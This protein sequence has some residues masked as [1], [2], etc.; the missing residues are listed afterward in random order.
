MIAE[1]LVVEFRVTGDDCPV[2]EASRETGTTVDARPPLR[3]DDGNALLHFSTPDDAVGDHLD[4]HEAIRYLHASRSDGR[5]NYRC[6]AKR[7]CVVHELIDEGFL[8][9]SLQFRAGTERHVGAV[10]G[11]DV[12]QGVLEAAGATVGVSIERISPLGDEEE[13]SVARRWD[14]TPA[15]ASA[16]ETAYE[17]GYFEVPRAVTASEVA[18]ALGISK[19]AFLERLRRAQAALFGQILE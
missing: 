5:T 15:Q 9:D 17:M 1:C 13:G 11:H 6:L 12:L 18:T 3:R 4:T 14:F 2:A 19:S 10:V 16:V 7:R 8:V